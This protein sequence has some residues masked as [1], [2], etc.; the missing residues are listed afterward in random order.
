MKDV[1]FFTFIVETEL[2]EGYVIYTDKNNCHK[3]KLYESS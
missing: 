3:N 2:A 1:T